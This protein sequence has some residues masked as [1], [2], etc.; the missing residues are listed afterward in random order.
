MRADTQEASE[1]SAELVQLHTAE[2]IMNVLINRE[3]GLDARVEISDDLD[4]DEAAV[5]LGNPSF[6]PSD[7]RL[8]S[9]VAA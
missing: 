7:L 5:I 2:E 9:R 3:L 6:K 8:L 1:S 4:F